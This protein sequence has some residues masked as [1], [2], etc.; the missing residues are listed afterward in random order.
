MRGE[1]LHNKSLMCQVPHVL[2]GAPFLKKLN[3]LEQKLSL[4]I[5]NLEKKVAIVTGGSRGI[6]FAIAQ[7][8]ASA[9]AS[10]IIGDILGDRGK[11]AAENLRKKRF[12]VVF[13]YMDVTQRSS[14]EEVVAFVKRKYKKI[15]ILVNNAGVIL[16]KPIGEITDDEWDWMIKVNLRGTFLCS[17]IVGKEM[18]KRK[19]GK[20]INI[21]SNVAHTLMPQRG[22][23][24]ITKAAISHLTKVFALEW[25]PY[26]IN[27][28]AIAPG[29]TLTELNEE[30]FKKHPDD[31]Q[32]RVR[33]HPLGRLG[34]PS[35][36]AG[37]AIFLASEA[38]N[39][40][41]GQTVFVDGG[42]TLI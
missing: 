36:Y 13:K 21:S 32:E 33:T 42:S 23:Y 16:R 41:T 29:T 17:Q 1:C 9:G 6:G 25:A 38:S 35:D 31:Y 26:K 15:D 7:A 14:I 12:K 34:N 19:Y 22:V 20:I 2:N 4:K 28:N 11:E 10:V 39:Y 5:F 40:M 8:L 27:V 37:I 3:P 24:A 30:Y 18:I